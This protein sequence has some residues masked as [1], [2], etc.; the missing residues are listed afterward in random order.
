MTKI[1]V[2]MYWAWIDKQFCPRWPHRLT[3]HYRVKGQNR[4]RP[5]LCLSSFLQFASF[6]YNSFAS[7]R[8]I[9]KLGHK[10][11]VLTLSQASIWLWPLFDL[12]LW[13]YGRICDFTKKIQL[14]ATCFIRF[15]QHLRL[16]FQR[17]DNDV[18]HLRLVFQHVNISDVS[19]LRLVFQRVN[20]DITS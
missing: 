8:I 17:V 15:Q 9:T 12:W 11:H 7:L 18:S 20:N 14:H 6:C 2:P 10:D 4:S 3:Y 16:I 1:T 13:L 19:H 5:S